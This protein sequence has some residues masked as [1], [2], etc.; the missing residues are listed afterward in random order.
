MIIKCLNEEPL[1]VYGKG[2]NIRDWLYVEDHAHA[3]RT[4]LERGVP[5]ET[6]NIG[7]NSER[8]NIDL[9]HALC[10]IMDQLRPR[11]GGR[12][13]ADLI[14]FVT[15]RP[16]HDFRY[17]I[18]ASKIQR[19]LDWQ[20]RHQLET[21]LRKTVHWYLENRRWW[22][23]ILDGNYQLQRLGEAAPAGDIGKEREE[24]AK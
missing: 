14:R 4:V 18:D 8:R 20:P 1:P 16:G 7:G 2:E 21:C 9:V 11:A 3:L 10:E 24:S 13:H 19:E 6:Y 15:D 23:N 17:A 12:K 5:G 22:Q